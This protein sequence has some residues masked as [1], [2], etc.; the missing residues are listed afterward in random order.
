MVSEFE[1]E[2]G[3]TELTKRASAINPVELPTG[4][5]IKRFEKGD[6]Y[7]VLCISD[8]RADKDKAIREKQEK[9][10]VAELSKLEKRVKGHTQAR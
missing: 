9:R 4:V 8:G 7:F 5:R 1:N 6:E 3:W 2:E 10:F